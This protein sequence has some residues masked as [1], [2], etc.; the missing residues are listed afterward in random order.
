MTNPTTL[1][2]KKCNDTVPPIYNGFTDDHEGRR[3]FVDR[4]ALIAK[5]EGQKSGTPTMSGESYYSAEDIVRN[6]ALDEAIKLIK[7]MK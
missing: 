1:Y 5:I 2:I 3:A 7:E 6:K 4:E